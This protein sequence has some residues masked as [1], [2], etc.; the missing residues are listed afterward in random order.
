MML[1]AGATGLE[2]ACD[3]NTALGTKLRTA[4]QNCRQVINVNE[5]PDQQR[6]SVRV[7]LPFV[8]V[9]SLFIRFGSLPFSWQHNAERHLLVGG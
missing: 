8:E 4:R 3:H 6:H 9:L 7:F 1:W 2:S 5:V